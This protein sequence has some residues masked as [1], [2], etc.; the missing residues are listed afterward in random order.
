MAGQSEPLQGIRATTQ[1]DQ[2]DWHVF[3]CGRKLE[4]PEEIHT[5]MGEHISS[6]QRGRKVNSKPAQTQDLLTEV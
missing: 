5:D 3:D 6:T 1:M 4:N 2:P